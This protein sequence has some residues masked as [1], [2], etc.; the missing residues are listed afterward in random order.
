MAHQ[1]IL[2]ERA[3]IIAALLT[4]VTVSGGFTCN[5]T[6]AADRSHFHGT[7]IDADTQQ[8]LEGAVVVVVWYRKPM[9]H[10]N[11]PQYFHKAVEVLTDAQGKFSVLN[12][13]GIDWN[14]FTFIKN[15]PDIVIFKPGYGPYPIAHVKPRD[16]IVNGQI[17]RLNWEEELL[18]GTVVEL[19]KLD[20]AKQ[21]EFASPKLIGPIC[22]PSIPTDICTPHESIQTYIDLINE[23][24]AVL[25]FSPVHKRVSKNK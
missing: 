15:R 22:G 23:Q 8:P 19:P 9:I 20:F 10:M 12:K 25:G 17:V 6:H 14:P 1:A 3:G 24:R 2:R 13:P 5:A 11:G 4:L 16:A 21:K 7:V 18:K